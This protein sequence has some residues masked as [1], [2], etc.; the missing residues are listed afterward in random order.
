MR[1]LLAQA[2][3]AGSEPTHKRD[4]TTGAPVDFFQH[5]K[6]SWY[7]GGPQGK[8]WVDPGWSRD[9]SGKL[10][11]PWILNA[12]HDPA[13][14]YVPFLLT[15]DPYFLEELQ[16]QGNETLG[17][18]NYNRSVGHQIVNPSQTRTFSWSLRSIFQL[19]RVTPNATPRWLKPRAYWKH[20]LDDNLAY[21]SDT[22]VNN[23][24]ARSSTVFHA[25]T[26]LNA[27]AGWQ[28][29][30]LATVIGW[31]VR[32]GFEEW[33]PAYLWKLQA[34]LARTNGKSGWPRQWCS[35]YYYLIAK[36]LDDPTYDPRSVP[37]TAWF[38]DWA[39][40][41][42]EFRSN[43]GNHVVEPFTD[44]VSWQQSNA[45]DYLLYT[46][47]CLALA[48]SLGVTEAQEPF[49]FVNRMT[50]RKGHMTYRWAIGT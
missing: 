41:W 3:A 28:E 37:P 39:A 20:I 4:E 43:K 47:G 16:F 48:V 36:N 1:A 49:E 22:F 12:A 33:R 29:D 38:K 15:G 6:L 11:C 10:L 35:P 40:A 45:I 30:F 31:G 24:V 42:E 17:W 5:P 32:M 18:T 7:G 34:T 23:K 21:F 8:D 14:S 50:V 13:L 19:A 46:R 25:A 27:I 9:A 44:D 26:L 2:E